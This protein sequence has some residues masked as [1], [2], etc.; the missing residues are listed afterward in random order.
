MSF[1]YHKLGMDRKD[2]RTGNSMHWNQR[3]EII[4]EKVCP[5]FRRLFNDD[6]DNLEIFPIIPP[7]VLEGSIVDLRPE[8]P[9]PPSDSLI[10]LPE[11]PPPPPPLP[12]DDQ[13]PPPEPPS[14]FY[15]IELYNAW[16]AVLED[17]RRER[18]EEPTSPEPPIVI[19]RDPWWRQ[20]SRLLVLGIVIL[21]GCLSVGILAYWLGQRNTVAPTP[22]LSTAT[23]ELLATETQ[24]VATTA[25]PTETIPP[26][27]T[28]PPSDTPFPSSV[29][30]ESPTFFDDFADGLDP[31]WS[32]VFGKPVV[33]NE[34]LVASELTVLTV[35]DPTWTDYQVEFDVVMNR[36]TCDDRASF[37]GVRA[38]D[39]NNMILFRFDPCDTEW[40][41]II[42]GTWT[43]I[44]G[45]LLGNQGYA[46][47]LVHFTVVVEGN[48]VIL[49]DRSQQL[50]SFIDTDHPTGNIFLQVRPDT[51]FDNFAITL[52]NP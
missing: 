11:P 2:Q 46:D 50:N 5:V 15:P 30:T 42:N 47:T 37:L 7:N 12:P 45:T 14:D 28:P 34:T 36:F 20:Y 19:Q 4:R 44:P 17:D 31:A 52:L 23:F 1:V 29:P 18:G 10:P 6:P 48:K 16:L 25:A 21:L 51:I 43:Q 24:L 32:V 22:V 8:I 40:A 39:A 38:T 13:I 33:S 3:R 35:G 41:S 26:T 49:S 27:E 9:V